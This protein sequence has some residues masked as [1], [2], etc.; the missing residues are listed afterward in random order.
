MIVRQLD[1]LWL[2]SQSN[3]SM[4]NAS[5]SMAVTEANACGMYHCLNPKSTGPNKLRTIRYFLRPSSENLHEKNHK[6]F[7]KR[8]A[9]SNPRNVAPFANGELKD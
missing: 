2:V 9:I 3:N 5:S 7:K 8:L 6:L 1:G 4:L